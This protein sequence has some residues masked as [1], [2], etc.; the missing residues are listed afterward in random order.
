MH[1]SV[2]SKRI[3]LDAAGVPRDR[4]VPLCSDCVIFPVLCCCILGVSPH[5]RPS[6]A[7]HS[8]LVPLVPLVQVFV[9]HRGSHPEL[10]LWHLFV[11][12]Q[13][14]EIVWPF[15]VSTAT[16]T[17]VDENQGNVDFCE[18][19]FVLLGMMCSCSYYSATKT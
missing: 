1:S 16:V 7:V 17:V 13:Q 10:P 5:H 6:S 19:S 15:F 12:H 14:G 4:V 8:S 3:R 9:V 11:Q 2:P 18:A